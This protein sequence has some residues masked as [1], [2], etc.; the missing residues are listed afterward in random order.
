MRRTGVSNQYRWEIRFMRDGDEFKL[1]GFAFHAGGLKRKGTSASTLLWPR[2]GGMRILTP[3][4]SLRRAIV[5]RNSVS[6]YAS[7]E[8]FLVSGSYLCSVSC[9]FFSLAFDLLS[10]CLP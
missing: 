6:G 1:G 8:Y 4:W 9:N 7:T 2:D 3:G 10:G 5:P